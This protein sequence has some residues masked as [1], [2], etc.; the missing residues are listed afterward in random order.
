MAA[1]PRSPREITLEF[2]ARLLLAG[3]IGS[4]AGFGLL[5]APTAF[6]VL[7]S[8]QVA[9]QLVGPIVS[10]LHWYG[11][12]AGV[13]LALLARRRGGGALLFVLP[14]VAAALC[15][16]SEL[17][18]TPQIAAIRPLVFGPEGSPELA[19]RFQVLH[20]A[21]VAIFLTVGLSTLALLAAQV[22]ADAARGDT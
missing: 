6:R 21:S 16:Y 9:G 8:T 2:F 10:A 11:V 20:R 7:P 19:A 4:W 12:A 18:I 14:L 13:L 22:R 17:G 3:W 1:H 5:V 15:A